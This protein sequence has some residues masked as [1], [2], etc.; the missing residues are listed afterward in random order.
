M[1]VEIAL[2]LWSLTANLDEVARLARHLDA[3]E[4]ARADRFVYDRHRLAYIVGR[5]RL[6]E[7]LAAKTGMAAG[8]LR[9]E[10]GPQGK[11]SLPGGPCF[12]L[13]HSGGVACLALHPEMTLGADIEAFRVVEGG[14]AQRFFAPLEYETLMALPQAGQQAG[15]FRCW[16]RKEALIKALGGGLSIPLTAFDVTLDRVAPRLLR[17]AE[18]YGDAKA[19]ALAH[20]ELGPD[21]VGA[22]AA[23]TNGRPIRI[24]LASIP[25]AIPFATPS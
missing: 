11:P 13:S 7:L 5:G 22:V 3:G 4:T 23:K 8:D 20:F 24:N 18:P 15:F 17:L 6:R 12:N 19:W 16:T 25:D 10:Y 9:F 14:V 2:H 1:P 21:M